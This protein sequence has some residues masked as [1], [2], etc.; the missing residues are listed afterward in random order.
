LKRK[1]KG[2]KRKEN[3]K[4]RQNQPSDLLFFNIF[5]EREGRIREREMITA[6]K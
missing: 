3:T 1:K 5:E 6:R 4:G 2:G